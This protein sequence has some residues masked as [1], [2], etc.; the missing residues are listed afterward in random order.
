M[1]VYLIGTGVGNENSMSIEAAEII[2]KCS[3]VI[4][5]ER[6][7]ARYKNEKEVFVSFDAEKIKNYIINKKNGDAAILLSGDVSFYSGAKKIGEKLKEFENVEV[8]RIA[9]VSSL[10][11]FCA[12]LGLSAENIKAVSL[13]GRKCNIIGHIRKNR[14]VFALLSGE[15]DLKEICGKLCLYGMG[16]VAINIGERLSYDDEKISA[17]S[18][19]EFRDIKTDKLCVMIAENKNYNDECGVYIEDGEFTR[20]NVPMTKA[21][22]RAVSVGK[23]KIKRNSVIFDIG[24]GTGTVSVCCALSEVDSLV[25]AIEKN[26]DAVELTKKNKIKFAADNIEIVEGS[27]P[28][29]FDELPVPD[30]AFIGGSGGKCTAI[31]KKLKEMNHDIK[32]VMNVISLKTLGEVTELAEK[33]NYELDIMQIQS[34]F[35]KKVGEH[36]LMNGENPIYIITIK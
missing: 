4:G 25:Y 12:K 15:N 1:K 10:T 7:V 17:G 2:K 22:V 24:S 5:A 30:C 21:A 14:Y 29:V 26:K 33:E 16:D 19:V 32:I 28:E 13:H 34:S 27:A 23:M 9:G 35:S 6:M 31:I 3:V 8:I 36:Y 18:A 20:G 11:Y